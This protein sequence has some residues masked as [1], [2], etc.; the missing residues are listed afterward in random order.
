[1]DTLLFVCRF[2]D[3]SGPEGTTECENNWIQRKKTHW[4]AMKD[5]NGNE[6]SK[7]S[8]GHSFVSFAQQAAHSRKWRVI[9]DGSQNWKDATALHPID[10]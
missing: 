4:C 2:F 5:R 6:A 3:K 7:E 1:M 8:A 10:Q 9:V